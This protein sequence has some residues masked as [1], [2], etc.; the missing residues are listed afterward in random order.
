MKPVEDAWDEFD[1]M[2]YYDD[3]ERL[4]CTLKYL[5]VC[6]SL[7]LLNGF[8]NGFAGPGVVKLLHPFKPNLC[9]EPVFLSRLLEYLAGLTFP[10]I[11]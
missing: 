11:A 10:Y 8:I 9:Y 5:V 6:I 7:P 3:V 4:P 2:D 1:D